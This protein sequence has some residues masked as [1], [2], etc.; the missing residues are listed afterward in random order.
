M[1]INNI[2]YAILIGSM[3]VGCSDSE[4][5]TPSYAD[6]NVFE[7]A[8]D[9]NSET[10]Q[11]RREFF[12]ATGSYLLFS[13]TLRAVNRGTSTDGTVVTKPEM[14]DIMA[15]AMIGY[16][17]RTQY[18]Y[19]YITSPEEQRE[20]M[21]LI[22]DH[23]VWR[24]GRALPY[25]F[26]I[27]NSISYKDDKDNLVY[28]TKQLGLRAYAISLNGGKAF[29]DP[30]TYFSSMISDM[31]RTKVK[32]MSEDELAEFYDFSREYYYEYKEDFGLSATKY[33][34][35]EMWNYGFFTDVYKD[36]FPNSTSDLDLWLYYVTTLSREDFEAQYGSSSVMMAKYEVLAK[37]IED[38][39]YVLR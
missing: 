27:V 30:E 11:I 13:D 17:S 29:E 6:I 10:A 4:D 39:G 22:K 5:T 32:T 12:N 24:M 36:L 37:I 2:L 23:L 16:G 35:K 26:F 19:E 7:P 3:L 33:P 28:E 21:N 18:Y 14:L 15:Y 34:D 38:L 8:E 9:D 31:V 25:A 1:K 20:A